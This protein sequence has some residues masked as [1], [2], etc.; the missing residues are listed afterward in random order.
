MNVLHMLNVER[1]A[2][3]LCLRYWHES[4]MPNWAGLILG[5][6]LHCTVQNSSQMLGRWGREMGGFGIDQYI[7]STHFFASG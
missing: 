3:S 1:I 7:R 4:Q 6:I 5:Q 2:K